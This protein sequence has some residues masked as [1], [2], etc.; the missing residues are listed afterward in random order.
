MGKS[1][2][3]LSSYGR[4]ISNPIIRSVG[5]IKQ[6]LTRIWRNY[7]KSCKALGESERLI[8]N[9][10]QHS[11]E[12]YKRIEHVDDGDLFPIHLLRFRD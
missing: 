1:C 5:V 7:L 10:L 2:K 11:L 6:N 4:I 9:N 12:E 3:K 8:R